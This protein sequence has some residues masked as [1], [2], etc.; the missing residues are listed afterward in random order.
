MMSV[1]RRPHI[2][3][4]AISLGLA[5]PVTSCTVIVALPSERLL[6]LRVDLVLAVLVLNEG[7]VAFHLD[8]SVGFGWRWSEVWVICSELK[9]K[10]W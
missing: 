9:L 6:L 8:F 1:L 3:D 4:R 5:L 10:C 2:P 7:V